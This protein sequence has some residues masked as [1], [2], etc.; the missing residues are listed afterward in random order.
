MEMPN[1][2][3]TVP[4]IAKKMGS[5][6]IFIPYSMDVHVRQLYAQKQLHRV[7]RGIYKYVPIIEIPPLKTLTQSTLL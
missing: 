3:V 2:E 5:M 7:S 1:Q 4:E 6:G